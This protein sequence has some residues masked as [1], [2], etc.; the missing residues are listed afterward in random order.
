MAIEFNRDAYT[1]VFNDLDWLRDFC[2]F[3][4]RGY[5]FNEKDLYNE[6]S[7]IWRAFQKHQNYLR[8]KSKNF[9]KRNFRRN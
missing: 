8:A 4:G 7:P 6:K 1:K 9:Q 3:E 2:R 5:P